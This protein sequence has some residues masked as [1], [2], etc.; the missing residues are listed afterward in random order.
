DQPGY[1]LNYSHVRYFTTETQPEEVPSAKHFYK[2]AR[3]IRSRL[4]RILIENFA[5]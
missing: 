5:R 4:I 2:P 3:P 1:E